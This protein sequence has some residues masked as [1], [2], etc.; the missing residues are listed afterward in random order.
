MDDPL[1][2]TIALTVMGRVKVGSKQQR[3]DLADHICLRGDLVHP[4]NNARD[5]PEDNIRA[6][7]L[8]GLLAMAAREDAAWADMLYLRWKHMVLGDQEKPRDGNSVTGNVTG[9]VVQSL[10]DIGGLDFRR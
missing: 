8:A 1:M 3:K 6:E 7:I 2:L 4:L 10:G 9:N 5:V